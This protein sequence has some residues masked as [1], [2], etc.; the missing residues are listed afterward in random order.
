MK[1]SRIIVAIPIAAT[2]ALCIATSASA[3]SSRV[4]IVCNDPPGVAGI[5]RTTPSKCAVLP[6]RASFAEGANLRGLRWRSWGGTSAVGTGYE[7]GLH[8]PLAH[9]PAAVLAFG[10][11]R[12]ADGDFFYSRVRVTTTFGSTTVRAQV[13]PSRGGISNTL[14][15]ACPRTNVVGVDDV[16]VYGVSCSRARYWAEAGPQDRKL[17]GFKCVKTGEGAG[18]TAWRCSS[19]TALFTFRFYGDD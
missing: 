15:S 17:A 14:L 3:K 11:V 10:L 12:C 19:P 13:C 4:L 7:A 2:I 18:F 5:V 6:P 16:M 1:A 8:L 9:I